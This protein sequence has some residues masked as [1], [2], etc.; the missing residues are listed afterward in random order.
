MRSVPEIIFC[1]DKSMEQT[2]KVYE[3]LDNIKKEKKDGNGEGDRG[4]KKVR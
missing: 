4:D 3:I 2:R 1:I